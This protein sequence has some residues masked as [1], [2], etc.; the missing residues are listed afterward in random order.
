[1]SQRELGRYDVAFCYGFYDGSDG[2]DSRIAG[3]SRG[4]TLGIMKILPQRHQKEIG[5]LDTLI[6]DQIDY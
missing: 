5:L 4:R 1:M 3:D 2:H 6:L